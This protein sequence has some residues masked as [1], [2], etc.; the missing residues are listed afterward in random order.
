V[1]EPTSPTELYVP[2]YEPAVVYG[3]WPYPD[4]APYY[5]APPADTL[6]EACCDRHRVRRG[7]RGRPRDLGQ[8]RL[9]PPNINLL[10]KNVD[11]NNFNRNDRNN[12][13]KLAAQRGSPARREI[14]QCRVCQKY[15]RDRCASGQGGAPDFRGKEGQKVLEPGRSGGADRPGGGNVANRDRPGPT[16]QVPLTRWRRA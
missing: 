11:I 10:N 1:I 16:A 9:G 12:F 5:F 14:Q 15:A 7:R 3:E 13:S 8:L 4:Y 6:R 2:Y